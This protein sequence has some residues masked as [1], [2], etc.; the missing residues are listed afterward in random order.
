MYFVC[1]LLGLMF[2]WFNVYNAASYMYFRDECFT[3]YHNYK[4]FFKNVNIEQTL[5]F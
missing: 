3:D 4:T 2:L 1:I 5:F